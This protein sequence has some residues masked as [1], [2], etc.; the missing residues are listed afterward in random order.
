[1]YPAKLL[2]F[3]EHLLLLGAPAVAVPV[4]AFGGR[5]AWQ[6]RPAAASNLVAFLDSLVAHAAQIIDTDRFRQD[7]AGG[8]FFDSNI[9]RGYGL[10]S[11]GAL[12]A[13]VYDRYGRKKTHAL[14]ALKA[15]FAGMESFFHGHS[16]GIDPL[17]SYLGQP[18]LIENKTEVSLVDAAIWTDPPL[19]FLLD[20]RL[21]RRTEPLVQWFLEQSQRP[22]WL[23]SLELDLLPAHRTMVR[24]WLQAQP[25]VFWTALRQVSRFQ[26]A[27]FHPMVPAT[28]RATWQESLDRETLT[29][30]ICGAGGGGFLLGF[31][32]NRTSL[33][34]LQAKHTLVF[35]FDEPAP[36]QNEH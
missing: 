26:F 9:P 32:R 33:N 35:P 28:L 21:P 20:S 8:I 6:D 19:V 17:T 3:G 13:A 34:A 5:W 4:P 16:S 29:F 36:L 1:M 25:E 22:D 11:S 30:K 15:I 18:L 10:G 2:L 24:G 7:I 14:S 23:A 31:A 27:H 12:C